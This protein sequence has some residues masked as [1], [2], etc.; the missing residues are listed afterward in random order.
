MAEFGLQK[1]QFVHLSEIL[2]PRKDQNVAGELKEMTIRALQLWG[3][4]DKKFGPIGTKV[5]LTDRGGAFKLGKT[6]LLEF[7]GCK[8][9]LKFIPISHMLQSTADN[10]TNLMTKTIWRQEAWGLEG[11]HSCMPQDAFNMIKAAMNFDKAYIVQCWMTN[12]L[13]DVKDIDEF[14]LQDFKL[15]FH[16]T[17]SKWVDLHRECTRQ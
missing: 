4:Y 2:E 5:F 16:Y 6:S 9:H 7:L 13:L 15:R 14:S 3:T 1:W 17:G 11:H 12:L 8:A 10:G